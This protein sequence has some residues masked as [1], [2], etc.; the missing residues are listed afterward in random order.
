MKRRLS[1]WIA[2]PL[3]ALPCLVF[4]Q[5]ADTLLTNGKILTQDAKNSVRQALAVR[6]GRIAA[7][8]SNAEIGKLAGRA[9][10]V[11]D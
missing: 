6:D 8:G 2:A 10:R 1:D 3:L 11:I 9:T 5:G 4:A 7:I